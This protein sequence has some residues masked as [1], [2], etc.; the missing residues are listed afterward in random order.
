MCSFWWGLECNIIFAGMIGNNELASGSLLINFIFFFG[1]TVMGI[2]EAASVILGNCF[3]ANKV[4][5]AKRFYKIMTISSL[6]VGLSISACFS[7]FR[8]QMA[9]IFTEDETIVEMTAN[10]LIVLAVFFVFDSM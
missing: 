8:Y 5:L 7:I 3:G 6:I 2:H 9:K 10:S 1:A 4:A